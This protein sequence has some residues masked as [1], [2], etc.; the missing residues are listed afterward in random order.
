MHKDGILWLFRKHNLKMGHSI[1]GFTRKEWELCLGWGSIKVGSRI[2]GSGGSMPRMDGGFSRTKLKGI[3]ILEL[4]NKI[5]EMVL[6][7]R[8]PWLVYIR[9]TMW[10]TKKK[11]SELWPKMVCATRWHGK[12]IKNMVTVKKYRKMVNKAMYII[13]MAY[14]LHQKVT[15]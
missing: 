1:W 11:D 8:R 9:V 15:K 6:E 12:T 13:L 5:K 4:G 14:N 10:A 2:M 7:D 3:S